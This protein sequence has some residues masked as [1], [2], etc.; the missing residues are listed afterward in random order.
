MRSASAAERPS[1]IYCRAP[2]ATDRDHVPPLCLFPTRPTDAITVPS[3]RD[4]NE[5][6][7][8]DDERVRNLLTS[9]ASTETH[10]AVQGELSA[11]RDRA[12][13]RDLMELSGKHVEHLLDSI[14]PVAIR[15][16]AGLYLGKGYA[17]QL[18][19]AVVDRFLSRLTRALLW[20]ENSVRAENHEIE[21][22]M[23]PSSSD[24]GAMSPELRAFLLSNG[25]E[26]S[27]GTGIFRYIGYFRRGSAS[28]LWLFT[29]YDG[30]EFMTRCRSPRDR[31]HE[32]GAT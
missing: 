23:A 15:T 18:D 28:S 16:P 14:L 5:N 13:S 22:R 4:C 19:Q 2:N 24:L 27:V 20:H 8:R 32:S 1:C 7:G 9:L 21:W 26:G 11:R 25:R 31:A 29:F 10:P 3:C 30:V 12:L 17:F 6:H